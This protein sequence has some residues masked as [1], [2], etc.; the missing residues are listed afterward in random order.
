MTEPT[1]LVFW[2]ELTF[3]LNYLAGGIGAISFLCSYIFLKMPRRPIFI[4]NERDRQIDEA[5][6]SLERINALSI[7][8]ALGA[9]IFG[10]QN[11]FY[12]KYRI[13]MMIGPS[14][15]GRAA[16]AAA[17]SAAEQVNMLAI[18]IF[19][20]FCA[21]TLAVLFVKYRKTCRKN[22]IPLYLIPSEFEKR[23]EPFKGRI[24]ELLAMHVFVSIVTIANISD[25]TMMIV[26]AFLAI[27]VLC[28]II[29]LCWGPF[30][31]Y[32]RKADVELLKA[33]GI[34]NKK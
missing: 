1:A 19:V 26:M 5:Y 33:A 27:G 17:T 16:K 34:Y 18:V 9:L 30:D 4:F 29:T 12:H 14:L 23:A 3:A 31:S 7:I 6:Q 10:L 25:S 32:F 24:V 8:C 28:G 22:K 21:T 20:V 15:S 2:S 11:F 13:I